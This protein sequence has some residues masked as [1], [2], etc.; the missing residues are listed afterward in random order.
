[1]TLPRIKLHT[2]N[3][4]QKINSVLSSNG[5]K[6]VCQEANCPNR[7]QCWN[8]KTATFL[9]LGEIC[10]RHCKFCAI[11]VGMTGTG[12]HT[13]TSSREAHAIATAIHE[14]EIK[15]AVITSVTRDDLDDDGASIYLETI[16]AIRRLTPQT[17]IEI[18]TPDFQKTPTHLLKTIAKD[19]PPDVWGHNLETVE[20]LTPQLRD[21]RATYHHSLQLL[22]KIKEI[23]PNVYTKSALMLGLG[24]HQ[25]DLLATFTDLRLAQVDFLTMGQYLK[26]TSKN[27]EVF[28]YLTNEEFS[29]IEQ[30][31][32]TF[33][34]K[35]V[36]AGKLVR[37]SY[38]AHTLFSNA[39]KQRSQSQIQRQTQILD[40]GEIEYSTAIDR[41]IRMISEMSGLQ[42]NDY[43]ISSNY[44]GYIIF[45]HHPS[46]VTLGKN[47]TD[48][49]ISMAEQAWP[50][51]NIKVSRGGRSTYH[52]PG[53]LVVYPL[54]NLLHYKKD[55][56]AYLRTLE[57][58]L[59]ELL[60]K[61]YQIISH[62]NVQGDA[63]GTG[64]WVGERKLA[65]IGVAVKRWITYHGMA[66]NL[67][68]D[69]LAFK[70]INPCGLPITTMIS[71][72]EILGYKVI[73][74]TFQQ[75]F[76]QVLVKNFEIGKTDN[77]A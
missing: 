55:L 63:H 67:Y 68:H 62:G 38:R 60:Q 73:R 7:H 9:L 57:Q 13:D 49:D 69:D 65:S 3:E 44:N 76:S 12:F 42:M 34:F 6:S 47:S 17:T 41:K 10:T 28:K 51:K 29:Q 71:L 2:N 1:M 72:E 39:L 15:Y 45:C 18:L 40:W 64:V 27:I 4:F 48:A 36:V 31:A 77:H 14:L 50:G 22:G 75:L 56:H 21:P 25:E 11:G 24:E 61:H 43:Q 30:T 32:M 19:M 8:E 5:I 35:E 54:I 53:Q 26:P 74:K 16:E 20:R 33:G 46:I 59:V 37:S 58:S 66:I 52:G 70:G 23:N